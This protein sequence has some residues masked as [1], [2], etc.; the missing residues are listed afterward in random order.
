MRHR[1]DLYNVS[2][3]LIKQIRQALAITEALVVDLGGPVVPAVNERHQHAVR[4]GRFYNL[5]LR[6]HGM[7][8]AAGTRSAKTADK[9]TLHA[10]CR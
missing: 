7:R 6:R 5:E 10:L 4:E 3:D 1:R 9:G 2:A 8:W